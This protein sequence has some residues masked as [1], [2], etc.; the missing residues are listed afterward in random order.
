VLVFLEILVALLPLLVLLPSLVEVVKLK[1][2][3]VGLDSPCHPH[4]AEQ[5]VGVTQNSRNAFL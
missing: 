4:S 1:V 2:K 3:H 5:S